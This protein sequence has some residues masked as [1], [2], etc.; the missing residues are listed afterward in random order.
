MRKRTLAIALSAVLGGSLVGWAVVRWDPGSL[1][2][3]AEDTLALNLGREA[4]RFCTDGA[5]Q[6]RK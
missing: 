5:V 2:E 1:K 6:G 3:A 4:W